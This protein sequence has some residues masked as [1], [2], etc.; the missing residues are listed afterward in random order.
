MKPTGGMI[1]FSIRL[2]PAQLINIRVLEN[3]FER[4]IYIYIY[5]KRKRKGNDGETDRRTE[6]D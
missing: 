3:I 1:A 4:I 6:I 2:Y 5:I